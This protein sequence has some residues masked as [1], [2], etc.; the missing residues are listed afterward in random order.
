MALKPCR[1]CKELV[2]TGAKVC[3]R[4]GKTNPTGAWPLWHKAVLAGMILFVVAMA[5]NGHNE[6]HNPATTAAPAP[7]APE[8]VPIVEARMLQQIYETNEVDADNRFKGNTYEVQG[9]VQSIEKDFTGSVIVSLRAT[10]PY[11]PVRAYLRDG[12]AR[13]AAGLR[14][15]MWLTGLKCDVGGLIVG[16]VVLRDCHA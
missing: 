2:S 6:E 15:G 5:V 8:R 3:P 7:A 16:S 4:C 11:L 10:N 1:E 12:E 14:P 13:R 9:S